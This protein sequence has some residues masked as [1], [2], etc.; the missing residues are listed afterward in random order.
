MIDELRQIAIFAKTVEHGSFRAAAEA[1]RLSPSVI[2]HHVSQ[3]EE[4][5]GTALLYRSTRKLSLT[6]DGERMLASAHTMIEAAE[7][8]LSEISSQTNVLAG[9]LRVTLPAVLTQSV[10][11]RK[12]TEFTHTY[13][14][15]HLSLDVSDTR[16]DIIADG[17]E[18]AIRAGDMKDSSLK[19]KR[20][21]AFSRRLVA[22]KSYIKTKKKPVSPGCLNTW[23]WL[24]LTPVRQKKL[25]FSKAN[26][27]ETVQRDTP[28]LSSNSAQALAQ[29]ARSGAGLAILPEFLCTPMVDSGELEYVLPEWT[30]D[31]I[32]VYA[33]WTSNTPKDGLCKRLIE[34]LRDKQEQ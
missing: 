6:P 25:E 4:R 30:V 14:R 31:K 32:V 23:N 24:E 2:S 11:M 26:L 1:L 27:R 33:V 13:P 16:R 3:L 9:T 10:L 5:L 21:F 29:L 28:Q 17:F 7:T 34:H 20:L 18:L 12:L 15:V 19:A 8:G 22:S